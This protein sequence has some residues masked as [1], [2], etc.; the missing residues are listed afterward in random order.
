MA[1]SVPKD[2]TRS[3]VTIKGIFQVADSNAISSAVSYETNDTA[4]KFRWLEYNVSKGTW[5]ILSDWSNK[6]SIQ[7]KPEAGAYW[8]RVEAR[9]SDGVEKEYTLAYNSPRDYTH[10][11]VEIQGIYYIENFDGIDAGAVHQTNDKETEFRWLVYDADKGVWTII[12]DWKKDEWVTWNPEAGNY[13]LRVEARSSDGIES[14]C[15]IVYIVERYKIMGESN[16]T[17]EQ[18][19]AYYNSNAVYPSFYAT[20]DAPDIRQFCQ[21]Y[22]EEC[23][24]EGVKAEVAFAQ[25]MKETGFLRFGG[26]VNISQFNFAGLG[27]TDNG[28][29]GASFPNVRTGI[30]AQIQHL[31]AYASTEALNN[32]CV[33]PRFSLV[34]RG[35]A[36]YVEWLGQKEN[37]LGF[38]W[39]TA[40]RYGYSIKNDYMYKL[41]SY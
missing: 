6:E 2:Y 4:T 29:A 8:L 17:L 12:S 24:A 31:K 28:A 11:Y 20:T 16:V 21:I 32:T 22:L 15:T 10:N 14:N 18:M 35:T 7:W 19:V 41:M 39:A 23:A 25:A 27:A 34:R 33:D 13:W 9:T 38:G 36:P 37:P 40:E 3:F 1:Y 26:Q 5:S 30:R